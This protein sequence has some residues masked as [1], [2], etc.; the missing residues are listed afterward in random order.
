MKVKVKG[1]SNIFTTLFIIENKNKIC[2]ERTILQTSDLEFWIEKTT[3][4]PR[5]T[6][7]NV[8]QR[9]A[10]DK[11]PFPSSHRKVSPVVEAQ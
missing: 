11:V 9:N 6:T 1:S 5:E 4:E 3:T 10:K 8:V 7:L 2:I